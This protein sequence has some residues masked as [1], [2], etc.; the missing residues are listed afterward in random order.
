MRRF[1]TCSSCEE[2]HRL[3]EHRVF[4]CPGFNTCSSCEEQLLRFQLARRRFVVSIHAPLARSNYVAV[5]KHDKKNVSIHAPLARSN[6]LRRLRWAHQ[7]CFN[8]C[9]SC[10]EQQRR[11]PISAGKNCFNTCSSCEEQRYPRFLPIVFRRFQ[12]MLLL[13]G[14]TCEHRV[15][16]HVRR[17]NTCSSCEEQL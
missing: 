8:T 15:G 7:C 12:Y 2:Q 10:E 6:C 14:A 9:S 17:F 16:V 4:R 11:P 1:N 3:Q 5:Q 13:Q